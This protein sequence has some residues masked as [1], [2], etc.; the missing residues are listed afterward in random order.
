MMPNWSA[1]EFVLIACLGYVAYRVI[2]QRGRIVID[3]PNIER[4]WHGLRE[5]GIELARSPWTWQK[6]GILFGLFLILNWL[7]RIPFLPALALLIVPLYVLR[8]PPTDGTSSPSPPFGSPPAPPGDSGTA[9]LNPFAAGNPTPPSPPRPPLPFRYRVE[10][11]KRRG[12]RRRGLRGLF[13][14]LL[15]KTIMVIVPLLVLAFLAES[16]LTSHGPRGRERW[17]RRVERHVQSVM[18]EFQTQHD[19]KLDDGDRSRED[20]SPV[21]P[22]AQRWRD[23]ELNKKGDLHRATDSAPGRTLESIAPVPGLS[24]LGTRENV[25]SSL[26]TGGVNAGSASQ[27]DNPGKASSGEGIV[28]QAGDPLEKAVGERVVTLISDL[29]GD[30]AEGDREVYERLARLLP[31]TLSVNLGSVGALKWTPPIDWVKRHVVTQRKVEKKDDSYQ[32]RVT[33]DLQDRT[34]AE[35][36]A[37]VRAGARSRDTYR[38]AQLYAGAVFVIGGLAIVTRLGTGRAPSA[39][40][41]RAP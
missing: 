1:L 35:L 39:L 16:F 17:S 33:V 27:N 2:Y 9:T 3:R 37:Q 13:S 31:Q 24:D 15:G 11:F 12:D 28:L 20:R 23:R 41:S 25:E 19:L 26:R 21:S 18:D 6:T 5:R 30:A 14:E 34:L 29:V 38:L 4:E 32:V 36:A 7:L 22:L 40:D 8:R 10:Q